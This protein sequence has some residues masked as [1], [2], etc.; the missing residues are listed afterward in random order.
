ML[1]NIS[2]IAAFCSLIQY[3]PELDYSISFCVNVALPFT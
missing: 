2:Y 1:K 3:V